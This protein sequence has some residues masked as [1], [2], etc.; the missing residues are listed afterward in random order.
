MPS[1]AV[2]MTPDELAQL[3]RVHGIP[4]ANQLAK[5]LDIGQ[6]TVWRWLNGERRISRAHALLIRTVLNTP[7]VV[8]T[9]SKCPT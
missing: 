9:D 3:M 1:T 6:P 5:R 4:N 7:A 2:G 8:S